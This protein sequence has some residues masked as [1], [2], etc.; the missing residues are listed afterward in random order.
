MPLSDDAPALIRANLEQLQTG[1]R[2]RLVVIGTITDAQLEAINDERRT[3]GHPPIVAEVVFLGRHVHQSRIER[4]GYSIDDVID[5]IAS[6]MEA[7]AV[8][9]QTATMTAM[10]AGAS[11]ADRYGNLVRDRVIFECSA[12]HP[13]PELFSVVPRGTSFEE[14]LT[15]YPYLERE[16]ILAAVE[17]A[18]RQADHPVLLSA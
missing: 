11:P 9:L 5:Q 16:D 10:E 18:A 14:T 17:Y 8:V 7:A 2:V 6:A 12:R 1:N 4:D 15:D 13:K 3:H